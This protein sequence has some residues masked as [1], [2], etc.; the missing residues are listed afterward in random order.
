M[1]TEN[2][3]TEF[4]S[5]FNDAVIETVSAYVNTKGGKVYIGVDDLG[6]PAPNF[7]IGK[8]SIQNWI[9]EIKNK[10]QPGI[11]ADIETVTIQG[12]EII[13]VSVNEFPIKPVAFKGMY[14][15]RVN[16]ANHQLSAIEITNL[17]LQSLQLSWD[18]YPA[19]GKS[20]TDLSEQKVKLFFDKVATTGRFSLEGNWIEKLE[21]LKLIQG[22][23]ITN[24]AWLLFANENTGYNVHLGRFKSPS[25]IIDDKML[26]GT[27]FEVVEETMKYIIGQIKVAFEITGMPTQR[28]EVFEYP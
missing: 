21:K 23:S 14:Y 16:G 15:Q 11:I 6:Q 9:N 13:C 19:Q 24:A 18:S 22:N 12:K 8:E 1:N 5:S 26:N 17:S 4:K 10:T 20:I 3:H 27:L 28:T 25:M 2:Q 7:S